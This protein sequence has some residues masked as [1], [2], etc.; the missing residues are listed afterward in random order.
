MAFELEE[1][2]SWGRMHAEY[3]RM[4]DLSGGDLKKKIL[5][6]ADGPSGFNFGQTQR[7]YDVISIDPIYEYQADEIRNRV[8]S[9]KA[10]ILDQLHKNRE[11]YVWDAFKTPEELVDARIEALKIFLQDY[12]PGKREGRY[13]P[14]SLPELSFQ[15]KTFEIAVCSHLLFTFTDHLDADFHIAAINEMIRV[16]QEV[17]IFPLLDLS[18]K[19][20]THLDAVLSELE[21]RKIRTEILTVPYEIQHGGNKMLKVSDNRNRVRPHYSSKLSYD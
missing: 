8:L 6:C 11:V 20:S 16:S 3:V 13:L 19:K 18:G 7:G 21:K 10:E 12:E 2:V 17:R 9:T 5:G 15:D 4:F 14:E 1:I